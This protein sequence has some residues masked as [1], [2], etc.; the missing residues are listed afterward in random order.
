VPRSIDKISQDYSHVCTFSG[1]WCSR[2]QRGVCDDF[3]NLEDIS[4]KMLLRV[5]F[6]HL[7]IGMSVCAL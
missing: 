3:V 7:F 6:A 2:R 4:S 1:R 5:G